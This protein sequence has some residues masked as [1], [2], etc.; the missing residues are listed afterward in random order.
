MLVQPSQPLRTI[1]HHLILSITNHIEIQSRVRGGSTDRLLCF[2]VKARNVRQRPL[3]YP[4][5]DPTTETQ[6][7][8]IP[9]R[10]GFDTTIVQF[11]LSIHFPFTTSPSLRLHRD[12]TSLWSVK[13]MNY[14]WRKKQTEIAKLASFGSSELSKIT[15]SIDTY[16]FP[17]AVRKQDGR[18]S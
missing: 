4:A 2:E 8:R 18:F 9:E 11:W 10:K 14:F 13:M 1:R 5:S 15:E 3:S 6:K 17:S 16:F 12:G 7:G